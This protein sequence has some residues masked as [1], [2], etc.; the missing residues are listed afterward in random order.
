MGVGCED[1]LAVPRLPGRAGLWVAVGVAG[2]RYAFL[3]GL[4]AP[5]M[6]LVIGH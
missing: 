3:R 1:V 5:E 6:G 4:D 2:D